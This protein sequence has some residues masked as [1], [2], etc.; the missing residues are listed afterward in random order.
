MI[1]KVRK[2]V[3]ETNSSSTHSMCIPNDSLSAS[4]EFPCTLIVTRKSYGG[5]FHVLDIPEDKASYFYSA[6]LTK[7]ADDKETLESWKNHF[8]KVLEKAGVFAFFDDYNVY[9]LK[10]DN[11]DFP[12]NNFSFNN[13][14]FDQFLKFIKSDENLLNFIFNPNCFVVTGN[15]DDVCPN[16]I[17]TLIN[18]KTRKAES[19]GTITW[20]K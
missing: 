20:L 6:L 7:F 3:F 15:N 10:D 11:Y 13:Y 18:E 8:V 14:T 2:S 9:R 17:Q 12:F 5:E 16:E 19:S 1:C 4:F